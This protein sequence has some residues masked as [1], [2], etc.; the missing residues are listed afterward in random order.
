ML[1]NFGVLKN[2]NPVSGAERGSS[3]LIAGDHEA[4]QGGGGPPN[5]CPINSILANID[6]NI[7]TKRHLICVKIVS[8]RN[9]FFSRLTFFLHLYRGVRRNIKH[10][11]AMWFFYKKIDQKICWPFLYC[12]YKRKCHMN[13]SLGSNWI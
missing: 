5:G 6:V 9:I 13:C 11:W 4:F 3:P 8:S 10:R 12:L 7:L 1:G 2:W